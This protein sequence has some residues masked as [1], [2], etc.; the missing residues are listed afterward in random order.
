MRRLRALLIT[1][2]RPPDHCLALTRMLLL[3]SLFWG[4]RHFDAGRMVRT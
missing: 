3:D 2:H 4:S 1:D